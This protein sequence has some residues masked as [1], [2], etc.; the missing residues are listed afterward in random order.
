MT[1]ELL[2]DAAAKPL[3]HREAG[4]LLKTARRLLLNF[5]SQGSI[6]EIE[7]IR[8]VLGLLTQAE[9]LVEKEC[10]GRPVTRPGVRPGRAD[11]AD[12]D[13]ATFGERQRGDERSA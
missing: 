8:E 5:P 4:S 12:S 10:V 3:E 1:D 11:R 6:D 2:I 7:V 9:A 13:P